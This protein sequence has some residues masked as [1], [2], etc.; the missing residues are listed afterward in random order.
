MSE[1]SQEDKDRF[2]RCPEIAMAVMQ[3]LEPYANDDPASAIVGL[4]TALGSILTVMNDANLAYM[5]VTEVIRG[6]MDGDLLT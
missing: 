4:A 3:A 5:R 2:A 1:A 6:I